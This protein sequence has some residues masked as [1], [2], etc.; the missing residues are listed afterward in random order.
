MADDT[1]PDLLTGG[2]DIRLLLAKA[3]IELW[4]QIAPQDADDWLYQARQIAGQIADEPGYEA[5]R[6]QQEKE[7]PMADKFPALQSMKVNAE[8]IVRRHAALHAPKVET[9]DVDA[10]CRALGEISV[11]EATAALD[12]IEREGK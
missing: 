8:V 3:V 6:R 10:I 7:R 12:R 5:E 11:D 9:R 4:S 1:A 2:M